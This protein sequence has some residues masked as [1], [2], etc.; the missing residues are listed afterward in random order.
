[1]AATNSRLSPFQVTAVTFPCSHCTS[2]GSKRGTHHLRQHVAAYGRQHDRLHV[3][4]VG[5]HVGEGVAH[6]AD[7]GPQLLLRVVGAGQ[8]EGLQLGEL[9]RRGGLLAL[10]DGHDV[11]ADARAAEDVQVGALPLQDLVRVALVG[12]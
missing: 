10:H 1:M 5:D 2:R 6:L 8:T 12:V 7:G 9:V 4:V 3:G 11:E